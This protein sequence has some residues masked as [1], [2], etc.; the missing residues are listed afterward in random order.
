MQQYG[1]E[2]GTLQYVVKALEWGRYIIGMSTSQLG[3]MTQGASGVQ[4]VQQCE[5]RHLL[6]HTHSN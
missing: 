1:K 6:L 3:P 2:P 5:L 4:S